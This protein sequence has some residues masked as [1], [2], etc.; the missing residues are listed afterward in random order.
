METNVEEIKNKL[1]SF[2]CSIN[3][4]KMTHSNFEFTEGVKYVAEACNALWL[5]TYS[6]VQCTYFAK[7]SRMITVRLIKNDD[8]SAKLIFENNEKKELKTVQIRRTDFLLKEIKFYFINN[9]MLLP[10]EY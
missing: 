6:V 7:K 2:R 4:Y 1:A 5:L 9:T 8:N 10:S 3:V